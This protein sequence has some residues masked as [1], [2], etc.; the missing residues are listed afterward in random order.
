MTKSQQI[1]LFIA[2]ALLAITAGFLLRGHLSKSSVPPVSAD[3]A[4]KGAAAIISATLPD[5]E[6]KSQAISQWRDQV[7]VVNFWASWCEPCRAEIPEFIELQNKFRDRGLVFIGHRHRPARTRGCIQQGHRDQLSGARG[8]YE[9]H[10]PGRCRG[11]QAGRAT[12][13]CRHRP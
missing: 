1:T 5:L 13:Y 7:M 11:K 6:G 8:G 2:T 12:F 9:R 3:V 10:V 4:S